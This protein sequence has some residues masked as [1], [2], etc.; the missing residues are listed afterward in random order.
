MGLTAY[1]RRPR[2][3]NMGD[4]DP[5]LRRHQ[6]HGLSAQVKASINGRLTDDNFGLKLEPPSGGFF[7]A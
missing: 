6:L 3:L 4:D 7:V 1:H 5:R 2:T